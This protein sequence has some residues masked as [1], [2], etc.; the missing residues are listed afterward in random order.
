MVSI[1]L[2]VPS[3]FDMPVTATS[4]VRVFKTASSCMEVEPA[5]GRQR[6]VTQYRPFFRGNLLPRNE[7]GVMLHLVDEQLVAARRNRR[8]QALATRLIDIVVPEVKMISSG[9]SAPMKR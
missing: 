7:V 3:T 9:S 2:I 1:G 8:P 6:D 5:V 4:F